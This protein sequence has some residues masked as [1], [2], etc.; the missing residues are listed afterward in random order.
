MKKL[1]NWILVLVLLLA[2]INLVNAAEEYDP[3][4]WG[5]HE[6]HISQ[7]EY[8]SMTFIRSG[9]EIKLRIGEG[10]YSF[11]TEE[12]DG[13]KRIK[14][15]KDN[16]EQLWVYRK[17]SKHYVSGNDIVQEALI[18]NGH[19]SG[20][21]VNSLPRSERE[22]FTEEDLSDLNTFTSAI[23]SRRM[24]DDSLKNE[25]IFQDLK[26]S[27]KS[28]DIQATQ[29]IYDRLNT[30]LDMDG[31]EV[32]DR[33]FAQDLFRRTFSDVELQVAIEDPI[34]RRMIANILRDKLESLK[35]IDKV[36]TNSRLASNAM[37]NGNYQEAERLYRESRT[38]LN[39]NSNT[40]EILNNLKDLQSKAREHKLAKQAIG[41]ANWDAFKSRFD[42]ATLD[43]ASYSDPNKMKELEQLRDLF[44]DA[45]RLQRQLDA[46]GSIHTQS[47]VSNILNS[48]FQ[49]IVDRDERIA[50]I[51]HLV[52]GS[53]SSTEISAISSLSDSAQ[54]DL[55][56]AI[57]SEGYDINPAGKSASQIIDELKLKR[58]FKTRIDSLSI[59]G[60]ISWSLVKDLSPDDFKFSKKIIRIYDSRY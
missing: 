47:S 57:D 40:A 56:T 15:V 1:L 12:Y 49:P 14:L 60:V 32:S 6:L 5:D 58:P 41:D 51:E 25:I 43:P 17:D 11:T 16:G 28:K 42:S 53:W 27:L 33:A 8:N 26:E 45:V 52:S 31:P 34:Q 23:I 59:P 55:L 21:V 20:S 48:K 9:G 46:S 50:N 24:S 36:S 7:L 29:Q 22:S 39:S 35:G 54:L 18:S 37:R 44:N 38:F 10:S 30:I 2:S 3:V 19:V 13:Q 4:G